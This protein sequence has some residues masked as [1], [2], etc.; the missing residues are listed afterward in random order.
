MALFATLVAFF[1]FLAGIAP[2]HAALGAAP[3]AAPSLSSVAAALAGP[4]VALSA[5]LSLAGGSH[6]LRLLAP[7]SAVSTAV[8]VALVGSA[9]GAQWSPDLC[10][11][12]TTIGASVGGS[13]FTILGAAGS[14]VQKLRVYRNNGKEGYLRG[15]VALFSDGSEQRA[16]VRKDQFSEMTFS[17]GEVITGMTLWAGSSRVG[18]V[19]ITTNMRSWGYGVDSTAKL[20]SKAV[21]VGSGV[22]VGFQGRA[23]DDLDSLGA[24][25][26]KSVSTSVVDNIVFE[27]AGAN[28]GLR[29][30]TLK[31]GTAVWNGTDYSWNFSGSESRDISTSFSTG[32]S[33]GLSLGTTFKASVPKILE[34]GINAGWTY[35]STLGYTKNSASSSGLTWSATVALS[36]EKPA[37]SC[38]AMVWEGRLNVRW[39][40]IQTVVADGATV[41][42]PTSGTLTHV[43]Y[44]KVEARC[45]PLSPPTLSP[46]AAKTARHWA[47]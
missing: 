15:L 39:S 36:A 20:S 37:V 11:R 42:F 26:L 2:A 16:G 46:R 7:P 34:S 23:G 4:F 38:S 28:D 21:N 9:D 3:S 10:V 29:L 5:A 41:S 8:L 44:G 1:G 40:G 13:D 33:I 24:V 31:E 18:R 25:F 19:D 6:R 35:G 17:D 32:G 12:P 27:K 43:A 30:V 22:L 47:A 45:G 14:S